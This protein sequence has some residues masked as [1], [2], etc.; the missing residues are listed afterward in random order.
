MAPGKK[1]KVDPLADRLQSLFGRKNWHGLWQ[2]YTLLRNWEDIVGAKIAARS[3]PAYVQNNILWISVS[4]SVWMQ[5]LQSMKPEIH[6]KVREFMPDLEISDIRWNVQPAQPPKAPPKE[7]I[8]AHP[9]DPVQE[10]AFEQIASTVENEDCRSA[11][12]KLWRT[13]HKYQ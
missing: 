9:P 5:H 4:D 2:T 1:N 6:R 7:R 3:E 11:L 10:K 13:Y 8:K 12:C